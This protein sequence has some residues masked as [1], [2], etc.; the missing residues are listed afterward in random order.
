MQ[1]KDGL[2]A[3]ENRKNKKHSKN[4][5]YANRETNRSKLKGSL[6]WS[7]I[8]SWCFNQTTRKIEVLERSQRGLEKWF[9]ER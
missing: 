7:I 1:A 3:T 8:R 2:H 5:T 9:L 6:R 4:L